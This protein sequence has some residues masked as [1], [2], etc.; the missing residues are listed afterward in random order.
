M[1]AEETGLLREREQSW[2]VPWRSFEEM[3]LSHQPWELKRS[4]LQAGGKVDYPPECLQRREP[5]GP[6][7]TFWVGRVCLT[8]QLRKG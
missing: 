8:K 4:A 7:K 2:G 3:D 1:S 5:P 6:G